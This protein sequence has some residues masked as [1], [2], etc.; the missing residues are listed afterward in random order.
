MLAHHLYQA[1]AAVDPER[2]IRHLLAALARAQ[3]SGAF[4]EALELSSQLLSFDLPDLSEARAQVEEARGVALLALSR[5]QE[6]SVAAER[7]LAIWIA[8][9]D[10]PGI[11]RAAQGANVAYTWQVRFG[12]TLLVLQR[13][14][15]ALS[16]GADRE[17]CRLQSEYASW[18]TGERRFDEAERLFEAAKSTAERTGD[19]SLLGW[20]LAAGGNLARQLG[21]VTQAIEYAERARTML[22]PN[23]VWDRAGNAFTLAIGMYYAGRFQEARR[24]R[25]MPDAGRA[26]RARRIDMG[27]AP[28]GGR[29]RAVPDGRPATVSIRRGRGAARVRAVAVPQSHGGGRRLVPSRRSGARPG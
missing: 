16:H 8:R 22:D 1:G 24:H 23:A 14:L 6:A 3:G 21:R 7:A 19:A 18:V 17:R 4:E 20:V 29:R 5:A 11:A 15:A 12:D 10:D 2:A 27:G 26:L 25:R 13:A 28:S 9:K